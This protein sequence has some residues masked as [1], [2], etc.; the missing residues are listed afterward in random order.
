MAVC[1]ALRI[2][3]IRFSTPGPLAMSSRGYEFFRSM[4]YSVAVFAVGISGDETV[5]SHFIHTFNRKAYDRLVHCRLLLRSFSAF[6]HVAYVIRFV[7]SPSL[8]RVRLVLT[9]FLSGAL[10]RTT[11][12]HR[13]LA[14]PRC[15]YVKLID[16][17]TK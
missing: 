11:R 17:N 13:A 7:C 3:F 5:C 15:V 12:A 14:Q 6:F 9:A 10:V 4:K 1:V 2:Q 16:T 8:F